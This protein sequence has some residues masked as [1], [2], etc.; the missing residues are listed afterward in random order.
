MPEW[1]YRFLNEVTPII[2]GVLNQ[3]AS[4]VIHFAAFVE[5]NA[6]FM[7]SNMSLGDSLVLC[8]TVLI[9]TLTVTGATLPEMSRAQ[10]I[11][12]GS[13]GSISAVTLIAGTISNWTS[14]EKLRGQLSAFS[15][16]LKELT[17]QAEKSTAVFGRIAHFQFNTQPIPPSDPNLPFSLQMAILTD[18]TI[19]KP[20]FIITCD[21]PVSKGSFFIPGQVAY[22]LTQDGLSH[23]KKQFAFRFATPPF[24]PDAP[25]IVTLSSTSAVHCNQLTDAR[26]W[27]HNLIQ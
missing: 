11:F 27:T 7:Y 17:A 22:T 20:A 3:I 13:V 12:W 25:L 6:V 14:T 10:K 15:E 1:F 18:E 8:S 26:V 5:S 21:G 2:S 4:N 9:I 16:S 24:T 19:E 23:D